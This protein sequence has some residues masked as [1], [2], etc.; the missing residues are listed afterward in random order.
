[1]KNYS[2]TTIFLLS[3]LFVCSSVAAQYKKAS[4][5]T[6]NGRSYSFHAGQRFGSTGVTSITN[7]GITISIYK[8]EKKFFSG[9][10][11]EWLGSSN[12]S[13]SS[14]LLSDPA[15]TPPTTLSGKVPGGLGFNYH[16]GY[17]FGDVF[18]EELKTIPFIRLG[19]ETIINRLYIGEGRL[20]DSYEQPTSEF[21][22]V[23]IDF[24]GG[25]SYR[26]SKNW[27]AIG[28]L[29]YRI[30]I[31]GTKKDS[32]SSRPKKDFNAMPSHLFF[33]LGMR[34]IVSID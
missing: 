4:F 29:G 32:Y 6:K 14:N 27:S 2:K 24:G 30:N 26:V 34:Y 5:F 33:N 10:G 1:M 23:G 19:A 15:G 16:I 18:D 25:L 22:S 20:Y 3:I 9:W 17:N 21:A 28:H 12:Y 13:Y 31:N 11:L 7:F 8:Q